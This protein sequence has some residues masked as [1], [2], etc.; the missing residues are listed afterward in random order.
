[1]KRNAGFYANLNI[2]TCECI[3]QPKT[4]VRWDI[5]SNMFACVSEYKNEYGWIWDAKLYIITFSAGDANV[6]D[7]INV[8]YI[9]S[10]LG[11]VLWNHQT[12]CNLYKNHL[13]C[14]WRCLS[15]HMHYRSRKHKLSSMVRY[16][17]YL[18]LYRYTKH[19]HNVT[20]VHIVVLPP[21]T[22]LGI[23]G[24]LSSVNWFCLSIL[25]LCRGISSSEMNIMYLQRK[26]SLLV[27][28]I[29]DYRC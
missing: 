8:K 14:G 18:Y 7:M 20:Y 16:C 6:I 5:S 15:Y 19:L 9:K 26:Y 11:N 27:K 3:H 29:A 1:M 25:L 10:R 28:W 17:V 21:L 4:F 24:S 13:K 22:W 2:C 23:N 12:M